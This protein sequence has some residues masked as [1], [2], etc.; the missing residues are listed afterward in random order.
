MTSYC[1]CITILA[2]RKAKTLKNVLN[3]R[4]FAAGILS[5]ISALQSY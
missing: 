4:A 3:K 5:A 2:I 1:L